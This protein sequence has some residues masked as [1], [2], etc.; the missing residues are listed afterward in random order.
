MARGKIQIKKI[1]NSTNRQVTY[2]KRRNGLFKKAHELTVLCDAEVS[3]VMV[4]C[5]DKVHDYTSPSTTTKRIFDQYQQTK[6]I[7]LWSSHYKIMKENLEKLK[8][9][10]M[11]IRREMRQRMGQCLNDLSFQDLQ[12][13]ESDMESAWRVIHDRA[14]RV[15][16]N[17]IETSKKKARN[18]EQINRK[19]QV[20]LVS[21]ELQRARQVVE[22]IL[23]TENLEANVSLF[24]MK[25]AMDQDPYGL[26]VNGGDYNSVM[27]F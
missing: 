6:G 3:L 2:S 14:D 16:T 19:L 20:E 7:D 9:V 8:E 24:V 23:L 1:E 18:V 4:S 11:K 26:V 21:M 10:N 15:L 5:T 27:G 17:Q 13:L 25:E 12:S 22:I